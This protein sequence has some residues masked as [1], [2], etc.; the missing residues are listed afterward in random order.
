MKSLAFRYRRLDDVA[1]VVVTETFQ[2][3]R[4]YSFDRRPKKKIAANVL[5]DVRQQLH[6]TQH[7]MIAEAQ[8][9]DA[10]ASEST[11]VLDLLQVIEADVKEG[12]VTAADASIIVRSRVLD[13]PLGGPGANNA[14]QSSTR[15]RRSRAERRLK[16]FALNVKL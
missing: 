14:R 6:R 2:R 5:M 10:Q 11:S 8:A 16:E 12:I 7:Q 3:I 13:E 15:Q 4:N 1:A 9:Q